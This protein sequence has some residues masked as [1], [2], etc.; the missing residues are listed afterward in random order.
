MEE[1]LRRDLVRY[2]QRVHA[3]GWVANH[4]GNLSVRLSEGRY[5]C[6]PTAVSKADVVPEWLIAVDGTGALLQGTRKPFSEMKLHLAA[7]RARPRVGAVLH[8]HPPTAGG[9]HVAS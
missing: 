4:D 9:P 5:L 7:Y 2:A 6:T 1:T 8:A 3:A